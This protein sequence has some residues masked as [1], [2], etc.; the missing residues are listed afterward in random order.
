M[1]RNA[2]GEPACSA[3]QC[4]IIVGFH[5]GEP[6]QYCSIKCAAKTNG[7]FTQAS[8]QQKIRDVV[9][10]RYGVDNIRKT[11][12]VRK[13]VGAASSQAWKD[14]RIK[15]TD[16]WRKAIAASMAIKWQ[17][18]PDKFQNFLRASSCGM[19]SKLHQKIRNELL[20][21]LQGFKSEQPVL[22]YSADELHPEKKIIVEIHGDYVHAN[23]KRFSADDIIRLYGQSY[24][25]AEK[26]EMDA[27]RTQRLEAAGYN[28]I[29]VWESDDLEQK[30]IE[31]SSALNE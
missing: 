7:G 28:V 5:R 9:F 24:T 22:N 23:P 30:Q 1:W 4:D 19:F 20:L 27:I 21:D 10:E 13:K 6:K 12:F 15:M 2:Y 29:V 31:I 25:A 16:E 3:P 26:W 18:E 11:D 17:N 8:T 14:G